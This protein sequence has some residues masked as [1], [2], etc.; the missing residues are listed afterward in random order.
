MSHDAHVA[1]LFAHPVK[2]CRAVALE[3]ATVGPRGIELDRHWMF[4]DPAGRF[5]SQRT[6]PALARITALAEHDGDDDGER[7]H[8]SAPG[9]ADLVVATPRSGDRAQVTVWNDDCA[10]L[11]CGDEVAAWASEVAGTPLRLVRFD[12]AAHRALDERY[13]ADRAAVT[14]FADGYPLL[15]THESS[16]ADLQRRIGDA[17]DVPMERFRPNLVI[18]GD[19]PAWDEDDW[20]ELRV[21]DV[22]LD[23]V[24]PCTRCAI[25]TTDQASGER[26][27]P[28]PLRTL[29]SFRRSPGGVVFGQNA[30]H[31]GP[32]T[33]RVGDPVE[34]VRRRDA[35]DVS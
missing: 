8:L 10:A 12:D 20:L 33:L 23:V 19:L 17:A 9:A 5:V 32:G 22:V 15:V 13:V 6:E 34:V 4:V 30:V 24:K 29:A 21:G 3:Q 35:A 18:G 28:E 31:R 11:D 26:R 25:T 27:G 1:G 2:S 7:L 14:A 16:L